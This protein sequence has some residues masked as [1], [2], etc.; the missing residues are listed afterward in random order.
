[1][2][3]TK[4]IIPTYVDKKQIKTDGLNVVV[5][6][7]TPEI[8]EF[9]LTSYNHSNRPL[10][11]ANVNFL[12]QQMESGQWIEMSGDTISFDKK[13]NLN[14][15][16]HRLSALVKSGKSF[17]FVVMVGV[18]DGAFKVMDTGKNRGGS[19][20]LAI[21]G[22]KNSALLSAAIAFVINFEKGKFSDSAKAEKGKGSN[23]VSNTDISQFAKTHS[24]KIT[25]DCE[26]GISY[27]R[28]GDK[29]VR[30]SWL[31]GLLFVLS[32]T[33]RKLAEK[34][35]FQ[36]ATGDRVEYGSSM[37]WLRHKLYN[38]KISD[39]KTIPSRTKLAF[40]IKTWNSIRLQK[41]I[42]KLSF[43]PSKGERFPKVA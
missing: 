14:N 26:L 11:A 19:D 28:S 37:Y 42:K 35:I 2:T 29:L 24:T 9:W 40:I 36:L 43:S 23:K 38:A 18:D 33:D 39:T 12:A 31:V 21:E 34:F 10:K 32:K 30:S 25:K 6:T 41:P 16:Q 5:M 7:I 13:S 4:L 20:V 22:Y 8:A 17:K 3:S 27:Y 15:G 1:M